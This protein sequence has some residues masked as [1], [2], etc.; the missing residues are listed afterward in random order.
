MMPAETEQ[1]QERLKKRRRER[2]ADALLSLPIEEM[3][4]YQHECLVS[5]TTA[6]KYQIAADK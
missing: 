1:K 5:E 4:T 6:D 3:R 2:G